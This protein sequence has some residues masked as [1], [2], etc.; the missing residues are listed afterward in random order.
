VIAALLAVMVV[1]T[2]AKTPVPV[3]ELPPAVVLMRYATALS[4]QTAPQAVSFDYTLEQTGRRARVET[5]RIFRGGG[6]ERDEILSSEGRALTTPIVRIFRGRRDRYTLAALA[7][8]LEQY[9][10]TYVGPR[11]DGRHIDYVFSLDAKKPAAFAFTEV[12]IDG[13]KFLPHLI[14]FKTGANAGSGSV[15]FNGREKW[16]VAIAASARARLEGGISTERLTFR[17]YR[18]PTSLPPSTF[19]APRPLPTTS[20]SIP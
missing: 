6:N 8:R 14:K 16:W 3:P 11:R 20:P 2:P 18:F 10:F 7:P 1:V 19:S 15:T 5:H 4:E 12:T 17:A 9:D 13:V